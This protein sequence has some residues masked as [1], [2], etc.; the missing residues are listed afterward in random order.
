M[1]AFI[2]TAPDSCVF[3][4]DVKD[5]VNTVKMK[6]KCQYRS[7]HNDECKYHVTMGQNE[8]GEDVAVVSFDKAN[9]KVLK[10]LLAEG[11]SIED[12]AKVTKGADGYVTIVEKI[13]ECPG[14]HIP[15]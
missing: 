3:K 15:E 12:C 5:C 8:D 1:F 4:E 2:F 9:N 14:E 10:K 6:G 13:C 7:K 11:E